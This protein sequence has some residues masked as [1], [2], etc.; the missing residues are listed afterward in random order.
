MQRRAA[1]TPSRDRRKSGRV[2]RESTFDVLKT[3]GKALAPTSQLIHSSPSVESK[4]PSEEV[5]DEIDELD[6]EPE[7]ERPR[8]S[9]PIEEEDE[10]GENDGGIEMRPPRLSLA[11]DEEEI[12][13]RSVEYPREA[14]DESNQGRPSLMSYAGVRL[15][16]NFGETT[17]LESGSERGDDTGLRGAFEGED[18]TT[19]SQGA[20]DKGG[21]TQD[22]GRFNFTFDFPSPAAPAIEDPAEVPMHDEVFELT[23]MDVQPDLAATDFPSSDDAAGG[24]GLDL[25]LSPQASLSE[26]PGI[27]GGGLR[28]EDISES[29]PKQKKL[30]RHGI[31]IPNIPSGVVRKLATQFARS[32]AMSKT[33]INRD[34]LAAIEQA[35]SWFFEQMSEDLAVYSKHAGRS[36]I[37][38]SDVMTLMRR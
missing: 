35:T 10:E 20:F 18:D 3:L 31:P 25:N 4:P 24:F 23:A 19:I 17:G 11:I 9:L 14:G 29:G 33:K 22:L 7:V 21:E 15:S 16:E 8:L 32:R 13:L 26:S 6:R 37:D 28:N 36:T 27:I 5:K 12:T 34:T 2:Q 30:S 1:N 38:E